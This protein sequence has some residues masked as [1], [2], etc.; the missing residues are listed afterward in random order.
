[1]T[2]KRLVSFAR[3]AAGILLASMALAA[4]NS[5]GDDGP[6]MSDEEKLKKF[7]AGHNAYG[8]GGKAP[9][10]ASVPGAPAGK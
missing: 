7:E 9:G 8:G 5:N 2:E 1:M 4:C 3:L 10:A 6:I